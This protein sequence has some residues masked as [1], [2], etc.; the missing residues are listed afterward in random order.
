MLTQSLGQRK[1]EYTVLVPWEGGHSYWLIEAKADHASINQA[2]TEAKEYAE[3]INSEARRPVARFATGVAGTEKQSFF[4]TT[5][6]WNGSCWKEVSI[7]DYETTGFLS[8][9][10]CRDILDK[11]DHRLAAFDDDPDR[12]LKK[13]NAING[14]LQNNEVPVGERASIMA[15]L[16]LALAQDGNLRIHAEPVPLM[17]EINGLITDILRHHGKEEFADMIKLKLPATEK[18]HK[19]FRKA[20]VDTLQHLREMNIRS[21]IN[22][23]DD[24]LG[25]FYETFLKYANDAKEMGIVLTP[26]HITRFAVNILGIGQNDLVFDPACGTGGFLISAMEELRGKSTPKTYE[27][28]KND[29]LFGVEQRD[30]VY[31]LAI[32]NMIFRGDGKSQIYD[33][34]CFDH[35]F[36]L[37]DGEVWYTLTDQPEPEG[38]KRPFSRALVNPPFKLPTSES[39]FVDYGLRQIRKGGLLFAGLPAV[40]ISGSRT[41]FWREELLKRHTMRACIR[42]DKNLFYPV[43]ELTYGLVLEAHRPHEPGDRVFMGLLFDDDH[44]PRRSKMLAA[45]DVRDNVE[46]VTD[47]LRRFMLGQPV[48]NAIDRRQAVVSFDPASRSRFAPEGYIKSGSLPM[49]DAGSRGLASMNISRRARQLRSNKPAPVL[50]TEVF[51]IH[52]FIDAVLA[53]PLGTLK[54]YRPGSVPVISSAERDNRVADWLD[55]PDSLCLENCVTSSTLHNTKPCQAF[56]HPYRFSALSAH[57]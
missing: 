42:F 39:E 8:P 26:R 47:E 36:W 56:W 49:V 10:Q 41:A 33:G 27:R 1:P 30:D 13:A 50:T 43:S 17:R 3:A 40:V 12:F 14:T 23:G 46:E 20:I 48:E 45:H 52:E 55:I 51:L 37:R 54:E 25:K 38:A 22:G 32:V 44:R 31:G 29:G 57:L 19:K 21:A 9:E 53:A 11:N 34:D 4:V 35:E 18:N 7:N 5:S 28:F 15:A 2:L 16:L 6:Y 24:A